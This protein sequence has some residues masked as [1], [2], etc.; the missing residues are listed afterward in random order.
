MRGRDVES[1]RRAF[2][3][4]FFFYKLGNQDTGNKKV[5]GS[6]PAERGV[7]CFGT[8]VAVIEGLREDHATPCDVGGRQRAG[9]SLRLGRLR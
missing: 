6:W 4:V 5:G 9:T 1:F 8:S 2:C 3:G 7:V